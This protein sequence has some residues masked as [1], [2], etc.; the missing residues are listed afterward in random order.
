MLQKLSNYYI[1]WM[2]ASV[3]LRKDNT[4]FITNKLLKKEKEKYVYKD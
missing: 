4:Y 2:Y 3:F 1:N